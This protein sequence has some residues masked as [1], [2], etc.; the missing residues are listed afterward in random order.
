[1]GYLVKEIQGALLHQIGF[2]FKMGINGLLG[3]AH[4]LREV[5]H[6]HAFKPQREEKVGG[7]VQNLFFHKVKCTSETLK[8]KKVSCVLQLFN[9]RDYFSSFFS[10]PVVL[11]EGF[12]LILSH[13]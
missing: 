3:Y 2:I 6:G 10:I 7:R 12:V 5:I 11:P 8:T 1:M 9:N 4:S 13:D